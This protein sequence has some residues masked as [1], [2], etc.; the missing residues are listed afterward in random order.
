MGNLSVRI[1]VF[2]FFVHFIVM[3]IDQTQKEE[4]LRK[5]KELMAEGERQRA[6]VRLSRQVEEFERGNGS[7]LLQDEFVRNVSQVIVDASRDGSDGRAETFL[8][9]LDQHAC[10]EDGKIR[11]RA[12]M[13]LSFCLALVPLRVE[14]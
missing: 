13:T 7:V 2:S 11:E 12:V 14:K 1:Q 10:G 6:Q 5:V 3:D 4:A 9:K 8:E